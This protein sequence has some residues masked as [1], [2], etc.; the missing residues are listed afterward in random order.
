M[1]A[2]SV[3]P[4]MVFPNP[5]ALWSARCWLSAQRWPSF[6]RHQFSAHS[7]GGRVGSGIGAMVETVAGNS[8]NWVRYKAAQPA[9]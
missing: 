5:R 9:Y 3:L 2:G 7:G 8:A 4:A 1:A 6:V